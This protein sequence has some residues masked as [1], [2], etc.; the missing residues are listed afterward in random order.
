MTGKKIH[1]KE[2][3]EMSPPPLLKGVHKT[4][5]SALQELQFVGPLRH[6]SNFARAVEVTANGQTWEVEYS[7]II[8]ST[9]SHV[10]SSPSNLLVSPI[11]STRQSSFDIANLAAV[12]GPVVNR[13]QW[14]VPL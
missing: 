3:V 14:V 7:P 8:D 6:W 13:A 5:S 10:P 2:A 4:T 9:T 12:Q 11:V 1:S